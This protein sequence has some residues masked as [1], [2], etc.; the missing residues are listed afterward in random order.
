MFEDIDIIKGSVAL[1]INKASEKKTIKILRE[2]YIEKINVTDEKAKKVVNFTKN[3]TF[4]FDNIDIEGEVSTGSLFEEIY[5]SL[6]YI[7]IKGL[8]K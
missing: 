2:A 8:A 3:T 4:K 7:N 6:E 5:S 1:L